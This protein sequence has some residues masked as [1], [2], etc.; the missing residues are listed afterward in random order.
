MKIEPSK[1][2]F[3]V[4]NKL[5][6]VLFSVLPFLS[7]MG[8]PP[9]PITQDLASLCEDSLQKNWA[10]FTDLLCWHVG[11]VGTIP[12]S[13]IAVTVNSDLVTKLNLNN[14]NFHW[15]LGYRIGGRYANL[16]QNQWGISLYYTWFRTEAKKE[17]AFDGF[18]GIPTGFPL[19]GTISD[20]DFAELFWL[21]GAHKYDARWDLLYNIFDLEVDREYLV[22]KTISLR[23][24]LGLRGGW[25]HQN[26]HIHSIYFD[27]LTNNTPVP[28]K[29]ELKNHFWGIGPSCGLDSKWCFGHVS[30]HSFYLFGALSSSYMWGFWHF[31]DQLAI[32]DTINGRLNPRHRSGGSLMFQD[33]LGFEWSVK[34]NKRDSIFSL[35]LGFESQYWFDQLEVFNAYNGRQHNALTLQGGTFDLHFSY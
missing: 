28:A 17:G 15:D 18:V 26:I 25:I 30:D 11:E 6:L 7:A 14:L 16:G 20:A 31:S 5:F 23:P 1:N 19:T 10:V 8:N 22:S 32:G 21:F 13:T 9:M 2:L 4:M 29:E 12:N 35:R 33:L 3:E 34:L 27:A 24:Y